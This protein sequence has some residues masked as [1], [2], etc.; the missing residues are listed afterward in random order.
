MIKKLKSVI[1][2]IG[3]IIT[4]RS[5]GAFVRNSR[6][7]KHTYIGCRSRIYSSTMA[8]YSYA[9]RNNYLFKTHVGKFS[10]IADNCCIGLPEHLIN[11]VS[12]SPVF[13]Q[14]KNV[15]RISFSAEKQP[16]YKETFIGNDVWI[17]SNVSIKAGATIG[18][19]A[20]VGMSSVVTKDVPPYAVVVGN[21]ARIIKYRFSEEVIQKLLDI[22]WWKW[23]EE[24]L[25]QNAD[26]FTNPELLIQAFCN[27]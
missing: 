22:E 13:Q 27:K 1:D 4:G 23:D 6:L 8:K 18:D 5:R 12:T 3:Y 16:L 25:K 15:L 10:S 9:G 26:L 14:G 2:S 24:Q 20:V 21:P 19:G 17:G 11:R 7:D